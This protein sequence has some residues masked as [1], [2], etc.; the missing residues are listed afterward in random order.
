MIDLHCHTTA[1]DAFVSPSNIVRQAAIE[2]VY[3][4]AIAD[5]DT[6]NGLEEAFESAKKEDISFVPTVELSVDCEKGDSHL[7]GYGIQYKS[8]AQ[9][10]V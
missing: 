5:H 8:I 6:V 3:V 9:N 7:L 10:K 2:G 1:S 4:M